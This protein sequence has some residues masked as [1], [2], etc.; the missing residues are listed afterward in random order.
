MKKLVLI[1]ISSVVLFAQ[2]FDIKPISDVTQKNPPTFRQVS[3]S[4]AVLEFISSV[5]LNCMIVYGESTK[6]GSLTNDPNM[7]SPLTVDHK[8]NRWVSQKT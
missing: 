4:E 8:Q 2:G 1:F 7:S 3:S 5:P 6:Y